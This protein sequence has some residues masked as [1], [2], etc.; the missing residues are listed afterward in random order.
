M[1]LKT[2]Q[3]LSYL[4]PRSLLI[5]LHEL[6]IKLP[7]ELPYK[8]AALRTNQL[9][10]YLE[11]RQCA[12]LCY[13]MSQRMGVEIRFAMQEDSDVDFVGRYESEGTVYFIPIQ[14][15]EFVP[16]FVNPNASLQVELD[17][18]E[19]YADSSDL[20]VAFHINRTGTVHLSE[21]D[22]SRIPVK[23]LWFFGACSENQNEW[24]LLGD[25]LTPGA[26]YFNFSYP[27]T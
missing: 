25:L 12:L 27:S 11:G 14:I 9:K 8:V 22:F 17:K 10:R 19:K 18:L 26:R 1:R 4:D 6:S 20:V 7:P 5:A 21:L 15:K 16:D 3:K 23:Q 13:A 24:L 2:W